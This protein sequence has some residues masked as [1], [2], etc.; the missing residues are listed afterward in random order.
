M[1]I[2][3]DPYRFWVKGIAGVG[4][5][6]LGTG[7]G[8]HLISKVLFGLW[9]ILVGGIAI[10]V[11]NTVA[12]I[13]WYAILR[14]LRF[15]VRLWMIGPIYRHPSTRKLKWRKKST[16]PLMTFETDT[17]LPLTAR[18]RAAV[19]GGLIGAAVWI[20]LTLCG[21]LVSLAYP[22]AIFYSI[23]LAVGA[24]VC[25][26]LQLKP[27]ARLKPTTV[28]LL[29][30]SWRHS[31]L[32]NGCKAMDRASE[33]WETTGS[34]MSLTEQD[35][36]ALRFVREPLIQQ[37]LALRIIISWQSLQGRTEEVL[38]QCDE[39]MAILDRNSDLVFGDLYSALAT[40]VALHYAMHGAV[41][42]AREINR[43]LIRVN[44][45]NNFLDLL[46]ARLAYEDGR[47]EEAESIFNRALAA[48]RNDPLK[49][50]EAERN[51]LEQHQ[52]DHPMFAHLVSSPD[53]TRSMVVVSP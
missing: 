18:D 30:N 11:A 42:K 6:L 52:I 24:I 4:F 10:D 53:S 25:L 16:E 49:T 51:R 14:M 7:L 1:K 32:T 9:A 35:L 26:T 47:V 28:W 31:P 37:L 50:E 29:V 36:I 33:I 44:V 20:F 17:T 41:D 3:S 22:E 43:N 45:S 23:L 2:I 48:L 21:F 34:I 40:E 8:D 13:I 15:N 27:R 46:H 19:A 38:R 12:G 5:F 39:Y